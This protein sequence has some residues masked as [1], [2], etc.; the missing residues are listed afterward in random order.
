MECTIEIFL[1]GRW[2]KAAQFVPHTESLNKGYRCGG[3]F[4]YSVQYAGEYLEYAQASVACRFP[5]NFEFY[6]LDTWPPFLLDILPSGAARRDWLGRLHLSDGFA[7]D[8]ELLIK[9]AGNP[10]GNIRI[11][12]ASTSPAEGSHAGFSRD[13]ILERGEEFI[14]YARRHNAPV[15]G[16]S[17]AQGDAPK[18]L[19]T[20]DSHGK[21]HADGALA[22]SE[23]SQHWIV[24]FPRGKKASDRQILRNETAYYQVATRMGLHVGKPLH[25]EKDA[26]FVPRFDRAVVDGAVHRYG[27]ESLCSLA[28]IAEFGSRPSQIRLL[29]SLMRF[30]SNPQADAEEFVLRD[31]L[32]VALGNTDNHPRNSAVLKIGNQVRLSPLFD[33]APMILDD[34]GIARVCHWVDAET[35]GYP[36]WSELPESLRPLGIDS[37]SLYRR[38]SAFAEQFESLPQILKA[39]GVD[40]DLI[41][42]LSGRISEV[43]RTLPAMSKKRRPGR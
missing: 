41:H 3:R 29:E 26:L 13:D 9:G 38:I 18:F 35:A 40:E 23:A 5:V 11:M 14:E 33:F 39:C 43:E 7:A 16:S 12:E 25:F 30:S 6:H 31:I 15:S 1:D 22:D 19:L 4:S 37:A 20:Q 24:K 8:W 28:N 36:N 10:I 34:Q 32:N 2:R 17:G 27:V 42:R 21:W